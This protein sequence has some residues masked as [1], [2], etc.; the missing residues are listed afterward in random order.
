VRAIRQRYAVGGISQYALAA[1]FGVN[2]ANIN[3]I[4]NRKAW[5]HVE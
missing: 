3:M 4:V 1:E 2:V 5:A